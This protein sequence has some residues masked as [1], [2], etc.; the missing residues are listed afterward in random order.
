MSLFPSGE[1]FV[2]VEGWRHGIAEMET[3][4]YATMSL[5]KRVFPPKRLRP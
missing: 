4:V 5:R 2:H 3:T 1:R